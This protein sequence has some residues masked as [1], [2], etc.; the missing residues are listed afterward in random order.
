M[1][2]FFLINDLEPISITVAQLL[3][4]LDSMEIDYM[5]FVKDIGRWIWGLT[6]GGKLISKG[7]LTLGFANSVPKTQ[8]RRQTYVDLCPFPWDLLT[9]AMVAKHMNKNMTYSGQG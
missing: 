3:N 7:N 2:S 6:T 9:R 8:Y 1:H 5:Y 4:E